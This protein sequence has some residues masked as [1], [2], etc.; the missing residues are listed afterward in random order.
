MAEELTVN[1]VPIGGATGGGQGPA[2]RVELPSGKMATVRK[3]CGRDL[4]NA[5]RVVPNG[6]DGSLIFA[7]IAE[8]AR[9]EGQPIVYEDVLAME[10]ADVLA[11]ETEV[12][13]ENFGFPPPRRSRD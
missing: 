11:L 13:D 9:V 3:G 1:G 4:I 8:L 7:L 5:N 10:L 6:D 2:R 12:V